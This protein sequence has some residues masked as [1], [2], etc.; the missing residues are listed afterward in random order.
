M[1]LFFVPFPVIM[2]FT[3][4][5]LSNWMGALSFGPFIL[6]RPKYEG[7]K[8]LHVHELEHSRHWWFTF[9]TFALIWWLTSNP[10]FLSIGIGIYGALYRLS[11]KFRLLVEARCYE[12]QIAHYPPERNV[13]FAAQHLSKNYNLG[14]S[15]EE[16]MKI[17]KIDA[18]GFY[19][20]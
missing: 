8:G 2:I 10:I 1:R 14:I 15:L 3:D 11:K 19:R 7:D 20:P 6:M 4:R 16:A 18:D 9:L 5:F 13:L 17:L 12:Q